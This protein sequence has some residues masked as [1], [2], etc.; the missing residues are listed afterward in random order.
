MKGA[1]CSS[2]ARIARKAILEPSDGDAIG[3]SVPEH[4]E[5]TES[6]TAEEKE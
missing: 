5:R 4:L 6:I 2:R 1:M 3:S